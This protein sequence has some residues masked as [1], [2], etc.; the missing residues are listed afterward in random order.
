MPVI[1]AVTL[2]VVIH[3]VVFL[4]LILSP[5]LAWKGATENIEISID[6]ELQLLHAVSPKKQSLV[7]QVELPDKLI[8][9]KDETLPNFL[10]EKAQRVR[11]ETQAA[12]T[13]MSSNR[14]ASESSPNKISVKL[15]KTSVLEKEGFKS[16]DVTKQLAEMNNFEK[17]ISTVGESLPKDVKI[18]SFTALNT[19]RYL[20]YTFYAR[21]EELIRFRWESRVQHVVENMNSQLVA[22]T[23]NRNWITHAEFLLDRNGY[24]K[25]ALVMKESGLRAFDAAAVNAFRDARVFP[26]PPPE[27]VREDG[28]IHIQFSFTV[29]FSPPGLIIRN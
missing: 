5:P 10:S 29:N 11:E 19:D 4:G 6:D 17:G 26:N 18:G 8:L 22:G 7:R 28:Y 23:A 27:L 16:M 21:I 15:S 25:K 9:P 13:G 20:Y 12:Q 24:L 2:S 14:S 1:R 3:I